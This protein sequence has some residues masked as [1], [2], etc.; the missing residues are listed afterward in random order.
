MDGMRFVW[1][2]HLHGTLSAN[3][4]M[5]FKMPCDATL[6]H[7]QGV[8]GN[9]S[10]ATLKIGSS[11]DDDGY[12]AAMTIGDSGTPTVWDRGDFDGTLNSDTA[13]CP[14]IAKDTILLLTL[15]YDGASGTAAQNVDIALTFLEG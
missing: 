4:A 7:A 11:A 5:R 15:D 1:N 2:V 6:V 10:D 8:A 9:D 3:A 12:L 14:H 13:E